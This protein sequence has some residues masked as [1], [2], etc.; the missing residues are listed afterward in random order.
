MRF[1]EVL[2]IVNAGV[3]LV[4]TGFL[5]MNMHINKENHW[6]CVKGID[7]F[8]GN[9]SNYN[10]ID[11][12]YGDITEILREKGEEGVKY[13]IYNDLQRILAYLT[14]SIVFFGLG[15]VCKMG[16]MFKMQTF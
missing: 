1:L 14:L 13:D 2:Q 5:L 11:I 8:N 7:I 4:F 10:D 12:F 16:S 3:F 15:V 6:A 9:E